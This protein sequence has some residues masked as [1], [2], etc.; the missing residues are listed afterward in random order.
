VAAGGERRKSVVMRDLRRLPRPV[1][2]STFAPSC[3]GVRAE[4]PPFGP[5]TEQDEGA[6]SRLEGES[7]VLLMSPPFMT[8]GERAAPRRPPKSGQ[9]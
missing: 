1:A 8:R 6:N 2:R 7:E 5:V 4:H 3:M 9:S